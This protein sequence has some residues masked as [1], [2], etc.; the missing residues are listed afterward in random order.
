MLLKLLPEFD[1]FNVKID[2]INKSLS[3]SYIS[4]LCLY[5]SYLFFIETENW[6]SVEKIKVFFT[7]DHLSF[8]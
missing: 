3:S 6:F 4:C 1:S 8:G 2:R 5:S 7:Y